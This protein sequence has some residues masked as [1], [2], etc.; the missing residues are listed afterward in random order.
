MTKKVMTASELASYLKFNISTIYRMAREGMIPALKFGNVWRFSRESIDQWLKVQ[1]EQHFRG[2]LD[3]HVGSIDVA[4]F[5]TFP[6]HI[7]S[8]LSK[9]AFN[10]D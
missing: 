1:S 6:L 10:G 4:A 9:E 3:P 7:R 2:S 5:R 8:D